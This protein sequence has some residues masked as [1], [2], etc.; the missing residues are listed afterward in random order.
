VNG[1]ASFIE[2]LGMRADARMTARASEEDLRRL[3]E[4]LGRAVPE[5]LR[6][7]L[8]EV[9]GGLYEGG[10]E[11]FGP[12]R[13]MIHDIELVPDMLT[14]RARLGAGGHL[15]ENLLPF[16]R[17]GST[18]HLLRTDGEGRGQVIAHPAGRVYPDLVAFV[19]QVVL[20]PT[21]P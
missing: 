19:E 5:P 2:S 3:E 9:G 11:F 1:L 14:M 20:P 12:T 16:H 7:L 17:E 8:R 18:V 15:E 13:V 4:T 10:H 21:R 6:T